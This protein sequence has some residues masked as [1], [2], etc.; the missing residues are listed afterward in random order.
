MTASPLCVAC[1]YD[2]CEKGAGCSC[3]GGTAD[4]VCHDQALDTKSP[5]QMHRVPYLSALGFQP[6]RTET[7]HCRAE[8]PAVIEDTYTTVGTVLWKSA[9]PRKPARSLHASADQAVLRRVR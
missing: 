7:A 6:E 2:V 9:I 1:R 8:N 5:R 3:V 4:Q